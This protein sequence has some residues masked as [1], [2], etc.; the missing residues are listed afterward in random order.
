M[1]YKELTQHNSS[2]IDIKCT[3]FL[4]LLGSERSHY[5][6]QEMVIELCSGEEICRGEGWHYQEEQRMGQ[7][8]L[9]QSPGTASVWIAVVLKGHTPNK[10]TSIRVN[11]VHSWPLKYSWTAALNLSQASGE[12]VTWQQPCIY[13]QSSNWWSLKGRKVFLKILWTWHNS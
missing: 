2:F 13:V 1:Y 7:A 6:F 5:T 10:N 8:H 3:N 9:Q 4:W 12:P 11:C